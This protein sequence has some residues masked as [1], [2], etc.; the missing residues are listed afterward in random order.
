MIHM[1]NPLPIWRLQAM[2]ATLAM[3]AFPD[4]DKAPALSQHK[5]TKGQSRCL[6][7]TS[8]LEHDKHMQPMC[9]SSLGSQPC[10]NTTRTPLPTSQVLTSLASF[11]PETTVIILLSTHTLRMAATD[12]RTWAQGL[13]RPG[14]RLPAIQNGRGWH[15]AGQAFRQQPQSH[16]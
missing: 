5:L 8:V 1:S 10:I 9:C 2:H 4:Y 14:C 7:C 3:R 15:T 12:S 16:V 13:T 6:M 11:S